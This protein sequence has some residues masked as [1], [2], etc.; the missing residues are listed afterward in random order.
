MKVFLLPLYSQLNPGVGNCPL[1]CV[2]DC[3]VKQQ[4]PELGQDSEYS[5]PLSSHQAQTYAHIYQGEADVIFN[6]SATADGKSL[7]GYLPGLL[8]PEFRIMGLYPTIELVTDQ[9]SQQVDYHQKFGFTEKQVKKR[10]DYLYGAELAIRTKEEGSSK[11]KFQALLEAIEQKPVLLT[12]PDIFHLITHFQYRDPAYDKDL[13]PLALAKWPDL[14]VFDEFHI[15]GAH[16][17]AAAL[18]SLTL[19]RRTQQRKKQFLFTSATPKPD[20]IHQLRQ[21]GFQVESVQGIYT[22]EEPP[23][24]EEPPKFRP[25]LKGVELEFVNLKDTDSLSWLRESATR[26]QEFLQKNEK[27]GRGRGLIILN[28]VALAGQVFRKLKGLLEPS[29]VVK[30]ISGRI[31]RQERDRTRKELK[32]ETRPVLVVGT[33]AVDVGVDFKINL[34]IFEAS[35]SATFVQRLGRLGRFERQFEFLT[36]QAFVLMPKRTPWIWS[37]LEEALSGKQT[38]DRASFRKIIEEVFDPPREFQEYRNCWGALQAHGMFCRMMETNDSDNKGNSSRKKQNLVMQPVRDRMIADL[39]QVYRENL[40]TMQSRWNALGR[41]T[42]D[43]I[44]TRDAIHAELLRFRGGSALQAAVWDDEHFYTYDLLRLLPYAEVKLVER[45]EFLEAAANSGHIEEEFP[46]KYI[47]TY[48]RIKRWLDKRSDLQIH[49]NRRTNELETCKL[50]LI[51][52]LSIEIEGRDQTEIANCLSRRKLLAFLIQPSN[53]KQPG[54]HWEISR[55]LRLNPTFGLHRLKDADQQFYACAFNQ[56][57][58]LLE[59]LSGRLKDICRR[60]PQSL[61]F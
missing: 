11:Y 14:W 41:G 59:A 37:G 48:L 7:A 8:D 3:K 9:V 16:Q 40:A 49:C 47:H 33:S 24:N 45:E 17:E 15:F 5:C 56:D 58:L 31:D 6:T 4:A 53:H 21:V 55:T 52:K 43:P 28:S 46:K 23:D 51:D 22:N 30:E 34:L 32:H 18:N 35:D 39:Q 10:V 50:S 25:I 54:S 12:N 1:G 42:K 27:Q 44:A 38:L 13:L 36:Y 61:I 60:Q 29:V 26:I 20:F 57:S 2:E 19:I